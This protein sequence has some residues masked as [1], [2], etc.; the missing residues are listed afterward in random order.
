MISELNKL[1]QKFNIEILKYGLSE[2]EALLVEATAI[3]LVKIDSLTNRVHGHG[4]RFGGRAGVD[5]LAARLDAKE[6]D[7]TEP[8]ILVTINR[9]YRFGMTI[10]ELYDATRSAWKMTPTKHDAKFA[11]S[12][13]DGVVREVFEIAN[14]VPGGSTMRIRDKDGRSPDR[15]QRWEFVGQVAKDHVRKKYVGR[16]VAHYSKQG[17]RN[18]IRY[19]NC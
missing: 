13:F 11:M 18:P 2:D 17:A 4:S 9:E 6:V 14:W 7:I 19:I 12:V 3:D 10:H 15:S 5:E 8:V 1:G 16:S